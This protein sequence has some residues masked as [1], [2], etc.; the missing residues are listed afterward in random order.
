MQPVF[1]TIAKKEINPEQ[2]RQVEQ[3]QHAKQTAAKPITK[4]RKISDQNLG[5]SRGSHADFEEN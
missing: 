5:T 2:K 4:P 1:F 3:D